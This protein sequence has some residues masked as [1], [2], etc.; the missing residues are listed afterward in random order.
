MVNGA[1]RP[2]ISLKRSGLSVMFVMVFTFPLWARISDA[3]TG[4]C[5]TLCMYFFYA[6]YHVY[7]NQA[8]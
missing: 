2:M 3:V 4:C 6:L 5:I 7:W 8:M 1:L